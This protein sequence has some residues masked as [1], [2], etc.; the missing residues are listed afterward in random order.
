MR[1]GHDV[2]PLASEAITEACGGGIWTVLG[3]TAPLTTTF[4]HCEP[5]S[6]VLGQSFG[7]Q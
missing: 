4:P 7:E 6:I 2:F 1:G 3:L 5:C